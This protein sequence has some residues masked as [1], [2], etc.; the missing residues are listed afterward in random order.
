MQ[1]VLS[2]LEVALQLLES[3]RDCSIRADE[4]QVDLANPSTDSTMSV[5]G[6]GAVFSD[7]AYTDGR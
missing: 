4:T 3:P 6:Q 1:E 2:S 5:T 7:I